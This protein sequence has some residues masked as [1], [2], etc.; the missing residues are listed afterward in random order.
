VIRNGGQTSA[1]IE[2]TFEEGVACVM[3]SKSYLEKRRVE[4]DPINRRIV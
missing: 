2:R 3:A 1:N 4:W